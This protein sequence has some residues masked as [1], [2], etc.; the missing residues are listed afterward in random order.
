VDPEVDKDGDLGFWRAKRDLKAVYDHSDSESSDNECCKKLYVMFGG[1]WDI[2]SRRIVKT[3]RREVAAAVPAPR[4][5]HT[6]NGWR[7]QSALTP[8]TVPRVWQGAGQL[9][10]LVSPTITNTKLY[11]V[12]V[13]GG[14][15]VNLISLVAFKRLQIP[16][17]KL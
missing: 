15:A 8:P 4:R 12:L 9:P 10:L 3:L 6:T 17:S 1:S 14:V 16:M 5:R 7:C 11:H 2:T 13:D